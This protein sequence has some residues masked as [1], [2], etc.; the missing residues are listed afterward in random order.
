[1]EE[2]STPSPRQ[3]AIAKK[4][5]G[6][7]KLRYILYSLLA[8]LGSWLFL[9]LIMVAAAGWYT[10]RPVFCSSCHNMVPYYESWKASPHKN[11][12]CIECH[13]PPGIGGEVRGKML[14]LV[15]V[16]KYVTASAGPKPK[17]E[18]PD[19]SCLRS[20]CHETRLLSGRVDYHVGDITIPFDHT[21][22][23]AEGRRGKTL[24][25][26]SC[27]SQVM[28]G[29]SHMEVTKTTCFLCH[30]KDEPFNAQ[31]SACTHCHQIPTKTFNL[32][33]GVQF[34]HELAL[35]KG[36]D[37][38]NCHGDVIRGKGE[39]P[40]ER[41]LSC[42]NAKGDL[43]KIDDHVFMH[44]MHVTEHK[45]DCIECHTPIEHSL[46]PNKIETAV[47]DCQSC[48][49]NHHQQQ[50]DLLRG[51]GAKTLAAEPNMMLSIRAECRTCH[52][53]HDVMPNGS[54]IVRGS[55]QT[56]ATCHDA[57]TVQRFETYHVALRSA[58]PVLDKTLGDVEAAAKKGGLPADRA[59]KIAAEA[60][61]LRHDVEMLQHGNDV[62]NM[63]FATELVRKTLDRV[64]VLC[65]EL[66][67]E[68]PKLLAAA[69]GRAPAKL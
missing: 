33:G 34:T 41:C 21:P 22:H 24:R 28:K 46:K 19:A 66:K 17:A 26:T 10:S 54:A 67:L 14:G 23:L 35:K 11:V 4:R 47:N 25:C 18:I 55:L 62:H 2:T 3:G 57:A 69:A 12:S 68:P 45:I 61:A 42:H 40:S 38:A 20:G 58:L 27:H 36:V 8:L 30:F 39:V 32:G 59:V 1:M 9:M 15:Q 48:H 53:V 7:R 31:L 43:A 5:T 29:G 52:Q 50:V 44:H 56:C 65:K 37:C 49:P 64:T 13:F 60:A 63:H 51:V 16:L 6:W